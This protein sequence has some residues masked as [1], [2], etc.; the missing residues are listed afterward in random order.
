MRISAYFAVKC[1]ALFLY[2]QLLNALGVGMGFKLATFLLITPLIKF[3]TVHNRCRTLLDKKSFVCSVLIDGLGASL[4]FLYFARV[5]PHL[6]WTYAL[7]IPVFNIVTEGI[8]YR[9]VREPAE[10]YLVKLSANP[11]DYLL[12]P[13]VAVIFALC[14]PFIAFDRFREGGYQASSFLWFLFILIQAD[15]FFGTL[16]V[17]HHKIPSLW[18]KHAMHHQYRREDL[19]CV[20]NFYAE[21]TDAFTMAFGAF[22]MG[23]FFTALAGQ[24]FLSMWDMGRCLTLTHHRYAK[25]HITLFMFWEFD[26]IDMLLGRPRLANFHGAHHNVFTS[27]FSSFG[28]LSDEF[29]TRAVVGTGL[30]PKPATPAPLGAAE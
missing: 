12:A 9:I 27:N 1:A 10:R 14:G 11:F 28:L 17:L 18:A 20:A 21:L 2:Y 4:F 22:F 3:F 25:Q 7:F 13:I 19:N 5:P 23:N 8:Q 16:H 30:I 6:Y 24:S 26:A 29:V 15:F